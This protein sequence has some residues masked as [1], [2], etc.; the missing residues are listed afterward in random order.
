M[1]IIE[2]VKS[3]H[4]PGNRL[5]QDQIL[6]PPF[7]QVLFR[8]DAA[9]INKTLPFHLSLNC[10]KHGHQKAEA[11]THIHCRKILFASVNAGSTSQDYHIE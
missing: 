8:H 4:K 11:M 10:Y 3:W 1:F 5:G 6:P 9:V 7:L 2:H